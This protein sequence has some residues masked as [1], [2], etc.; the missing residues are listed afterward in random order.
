MEFKPIGF[1]KS[2]KV[3]RKNL[4]LRP[5]FTPDAEVPTLAKIAI[6][7]YIGLVLT[8]SV[9]MSR[10]SLVKL[11]RNMNTWF[12][13]DPKISVWFLTGLMGLGDCHNR[14][15]LTLEDVAQVCVRSVGAF[16]SLL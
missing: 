4:I 9:K 13:Q 10:G 12:S 3:P 7:S 1:K 11:M 14:W 2:F 8:N 15:T 16:E 5:L 6:T